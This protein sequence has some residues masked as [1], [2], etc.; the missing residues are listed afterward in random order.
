M[1]QR[2]Q[3][4]RQQESKPAVFDEEK[5]FSDERLFGREEVEK[6]PSGKW[7]PADFQDGKHNLWDEEESKEEEVLSGEVSELWTAED[8]DFELNRHWEAESEEDILEREPLWQNE[9]VKEEGF[10]RESLWHE[11]ECECKKHPD[12]C[13]EHDHCHDH[14]KEDCEVI[15]EKTVYCKEEKNYYHKVKHIIPVVC[16]KVE[17][18]HYNHEYIIKKEVIKK[19]HRYDHG[20][21]EEDWCKVAG[22]SNGCKKECECEE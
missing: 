13:H 10:E 6:T 16:K 14:G 1:K 8:E 17:N 7:Y 15:R 4:K 3:S 22:C 21:R 9:G 19:E 5:F 18:H 2:Y 11:D 12:H 20:K